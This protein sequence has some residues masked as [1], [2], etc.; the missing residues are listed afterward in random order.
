MPQEEDGTY[1]IDGSAL[2]RDVNRALAWQLP[3]IGP[4]TMNGL[5]LEHLESFPDGNVSVR[6]GPYVLETVLVAENLV[7]TIRASVLPA[8]TA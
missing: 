2:V 1:T 5:V 7:R 8:K 4:R 6:I 3:T